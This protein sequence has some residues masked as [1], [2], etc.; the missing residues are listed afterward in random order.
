MAGQ[1]IARGNCRVQK[2]KIAL[3]GMVPDRFVLWMLK[4]LLKNLWTARRLPC[5]VT[6]EAIYLGQPGLLWSLWRKFHWRKRGKMLRGN[7][8]HIQISFSFVCRQGYSRGSF[9]YTV[10]WE[11]M[12]GMDLP[13]GNQPLRAKKW[14]EWRRKGVELSPD[15]FD[16]K[17]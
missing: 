3:P 14:K 1:K 7:H 12:K 10:N 15:R 5:T 8:G 17:L 11:G 6:G 13:L 9:N 16:R 4:F 2:E